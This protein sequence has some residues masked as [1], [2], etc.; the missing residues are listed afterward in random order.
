[1]NL[2]NFGETS[3]TSTT[4]TNDAIAAIAIRID[5]TTSLLNQMASTSFFDVEDRPQELAFERSRFSK[6]TIKRLRQNPGNWRAVP[7][8]K[9]SEDYEIFWTEMEV[10]ADELKNSAI[11]N[12]Q[13][14]EEV[15]TR[16]WQLYEALED[17]TVR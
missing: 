17:V 14:L 7:A 6:S 3:R 16:T 1:M 10:A 11:S 2:R 15:L 13:W 9:V 12:A 8:C 5:A 4:T